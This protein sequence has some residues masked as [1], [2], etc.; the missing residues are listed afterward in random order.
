MRG[1][2]TGEVAALLARLRL[3]KEE[4][5]K[6][7]ANPATNPVGPFHD[8]SA[9]NSAFKGFGKS[10]MHTIVYQFVMEKWP[11]A[12]ENM[13]ENGVQAYMN[14]KVLGKFAK[15]LG[16]HRVYDEFNSE[17]IL[18][19]RLKNIVF[20]LVGYFSHSHGFAEA[21]KFVKEMLLSNTS[22]NL[23]EILKI[24]EP[25]RLVQELLNIKVEFKILKESGRFSHSPV[26]EIG[27][28]NDTQLLG[29]G[30]GNS[31]P[32]AEHRACMQY[33][34]KHYENKI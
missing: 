17:K 26:F 24:D 7:F 6:I 27:A 18:D 30:I 33:L 16:I 10:A 3:P 1:V 15:Q 4:A 14:S 31:I 2:Q 23:D 9:T 34:L 19:G 22:L 20:A 28:F 21:Q 32:M 8:T 29:I 25:R 12:P 5:S 13:I 11:R